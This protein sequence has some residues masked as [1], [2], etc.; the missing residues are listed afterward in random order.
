MFLALAMD[1]KN[2]IWAW[3]VLRWGGT[4]KFEKQLNERIHFRADVALPRDSA[5][6]VTVI[7]KA[8]ALISVS[9]P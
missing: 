5:K 9:N 8:F 4:E 1:I 7:L 2:S 6:P 3:R